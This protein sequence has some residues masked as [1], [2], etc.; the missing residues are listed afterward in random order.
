MRIDVRPMN[1]EVATGAVLETRGQLVVEIR[2]VRRAKIANVAV[3]FQAK[4]P[5][6][7]A[8]EQLGVSRPMRVMTNLATLDLQW[9][10]L[11]DEWTLFVRMTL[12]A[13]HIRTHRQSRLLE[14]ESAVRVV[15]VAALD[16]PFEHFVVKGHI[17]LRFHLGVAAQTQLRL[18]HFQLLQSRSV[19]FQLRR[20]RNKR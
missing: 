18:A 3:A 16:L 8:L 1:P 7:R 10:M 17:E 20:A 11:E 4:L 2:R 14:L 5:H 19:R 15:T 12:Q 9:R 13:G 6:L